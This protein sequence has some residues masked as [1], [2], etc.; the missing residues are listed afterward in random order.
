MLRILVSLLVL[1]LAA[2]AQRSAFE[3]KT[4][5]AV[6]YQ[7]PEQPLD[8]RDLERVQILHPGSPLRSAD[9][10]EAIE[11][12]FA[13]GR[14]ADIQVAA[15]PTDNGV[16]V[17]FVTRENRFIGHVETRGKID[18]PPSAAQIVAAA[19]FTLGTRFEPEMLEQARKNIQQLYTSNGLYEA[20]VVLDTLDDPAHEQT[21]IRISVDP[22]VR[23]RYARPTIRGDTRI[24]EDTIIR[25]TGWRVRLIGRW[26]EVTDALT[27]GAVDGIEKRYRSQNRLTA[28]VDVSSLDYDPETVRAKASITVN[29]GPRINVNA[30]E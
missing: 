26:K 21:G 6:Q 18:N 23:A 16:I 20:K 8:S 19:Q 17:R 30:L 13:T 29:A 4:I 5:V 11:R 2:T 9:V 15:E 22:G 14:Y 1:S 3:G 10:A 25:A 27:R 28:T 12:M 7:P 24:P